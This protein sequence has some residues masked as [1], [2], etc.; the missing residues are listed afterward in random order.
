METRRCESDR[1][2]LLGKLLIIVCLSFC[3]RDITDRFQ[4]PRV[5]KPSDPFQGRKF[6]GFPAFPGCLVMDQFRLVQTIEG[7]GQ[8]VV[9]AVPLAADGRF[10]TGFRQAFGIT[11][12]NL[13]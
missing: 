3:R 12:C 9:I 5:V 10:N 11:D 13:L 2:G 8:G 4:S 7:L 1:Q 6:D